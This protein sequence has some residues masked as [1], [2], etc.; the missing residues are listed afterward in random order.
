MPAIGWINLDGIG[1][2][3]V[4]GDEQ[5]WVCDDDPD[6]AEALNKVIP[7]EEREWQGGVG[8]AALLKAGELFGVDPIIPLDNR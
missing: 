6:F 3:A 4:D 2:I 5:E 1:R 8:R 7:V